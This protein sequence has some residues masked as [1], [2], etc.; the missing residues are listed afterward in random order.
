MKRKTERLIIVVIAVLFISFNTILLLYKNVE[1]LKLEKNVSI[2]SESLK[3][4]NKQKNVSA[5]YEGKFLHEILDGNQINLAHTFLD[6]NESY[7]IL[8][9]VNSITCISC[10]KFHVENITTLSGINIR[11]YSKN[12][13]KLLNSYFEKNKIIKTKLNILYNSFDML[14]LFMDKNYRILYVEL[15]D[16]LNYNKSK[17]FYKKIKQFAGDR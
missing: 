17:I 7:H 8:F 12:E 10:F 14:V 16:K 1:I 9:V 11:V 5:F 6:A 13:I 4:H 15:P 2:A 3:N